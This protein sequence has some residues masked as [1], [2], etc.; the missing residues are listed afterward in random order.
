M[1]LYS[2]KLTT[3]RNSSGGNIQG[4]RDQRSAGILFVGIGKMG[5]PMAD[6]LSAAGHMVNVRDVDQAAVAR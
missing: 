3:S 2:R 1:A 4:P 5:M 6:R